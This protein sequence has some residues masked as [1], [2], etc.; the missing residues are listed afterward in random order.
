MTVVAEEARVVVVLLDVVRDHI[1]IPVGITFGDDALGELRQG[2][3]GITTH[4]TIGDRPVV[5]VIAAFDAVVDEW[6][7][8]R[9]REE[10]ADAGIV[11]DGE[12]VAVQLAAVD[13]E[14]T[15]A[16]REVVFPRLAR[17]QHP[18]TSVGVDAEDRDVGVLVELE[19]GPDP[20]A[21]GK[22]RTVAAI[23]PQ[24]DA[25]AIDGTDRSPVTNQR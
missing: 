4:A 22:N 2:N 14:L 18:H 3:I 1:V 21:A 10:V 16:P 13:L 20:L 25:W 9:H 12:R 19:E 8:G 5:P 11:I 23:G 17:E 24:L 6:I 7:G 15:P